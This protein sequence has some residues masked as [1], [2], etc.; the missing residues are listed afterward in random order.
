MLK[1]LTFIAKW[2]LKPREYQCSISRMSP[3]ELAE[4]SILFQTFPSISSVDAIRCI[5][6]IW[7]RCTLHLL[8]LFMPQSAHL[9]TELGLSAI[10]SITSLVKWYYWGKDWQIKGTTFLLTANY[11]LHWD[12]V[13]DWRSPAAAGGSVPFYLPVSALRL[14]RS[15]MKIF[16]KCQTGHLYVFSYLLFS[17]WR[18][19]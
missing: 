16:L 2:K 4:C 11:K 8:Q 13:T 9:T 17:I 12:V 3:P 1:I 5:Q 18:P 10:W 7:E 15:S 14:S 6:A 19:T